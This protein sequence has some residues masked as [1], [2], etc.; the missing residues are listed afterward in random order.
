V[1][2][3]SDWHVDCTPVIA[4]CRLLRCLRQI[5]LPELLGSGSFGNE[6]VARDDIGER[7]LE[8][9]MAIEC[10]FYQIFLCCIKPVYVSVL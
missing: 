5:E 8:C 7:L 10:L 2:C 9:A 3:Y 4:E 6:V 1:V